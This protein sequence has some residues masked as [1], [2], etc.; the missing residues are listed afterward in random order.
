MG[1]DGM[2]DGKREKLEGG[3][4]KGRV[5][6]G[7]EKKRGIEGVWWV[8]WLVG[9]VGSVGP[10]AI[11]FRTSGWVSGGVYLG[12]HCMCSTGWGRQGLGEKGAMWGER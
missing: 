12:V 9:S 5:G 10:L 2:G 8:G 6:Q 1:W 3:E 4:V 11:E 7:R